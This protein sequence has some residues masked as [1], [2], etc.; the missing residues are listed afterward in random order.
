M[1]LKN[2]WRQN[3][4][5]WLSDGMRVQGAGV[6][7]LDWTC[8]L[9]TQEEGGKEIWVEEMSSAS[10]LWSRIKPLSWDSQ[11]TY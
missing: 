1:D 4:W 7:F 6:R 9:G 10:D 3:Q 8:E 5:D 2:I 11:G